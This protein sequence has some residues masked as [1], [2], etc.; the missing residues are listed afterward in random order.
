MVALEGVLANYGLDFGDISGMTTDG[1]SAMVKLAKLIATRRGSRPFYHQQCLAHELHLAVSAALGGN[2]VNASEPDHSMPGSSGGPASQAAGD[3][4]CDQPEE[5]EE[6]VAEREMIPPEVDCDLIRK[7]RSVVQEFRYSG[8]NSDI[9][10]DVCRSNGF[11]HLVAL[12]DLSFRWNS[13]LKM[14]TRFLEIEEPLRAY[15]RRKK[16]N[17]PLSNSEVEGI[18]S[19]VP[20]LQ[21]VAEASTRLQKHGSTLFD[22]EL[23]LQVC[24][25]LN[26]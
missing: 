26:T 4:R 16:E 19:I 5:E 7:V 2:P 18:R 17:F 8:T 22:A 6:P 12:P 10:E 11:K 15:Y 9:F 14:L 25:T 23:I 21:I 1:A 24:L 20:A 13:T 3:L